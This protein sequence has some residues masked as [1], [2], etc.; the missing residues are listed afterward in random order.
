MA[1]ASDAEPKGPHW[2]HFLTLPLLKQQFAGTSPA[3]YAAVAGYKDE[4]LSKDVLTRDDV[5]NFCQDPETDPWIAFITIMAWGAQD[6]MPG[7]KSKVVAMFSQKEQ[8]LRNMECTLS[9]DNN[10][11]AFEIWSK[12]PVNKLGVAY[13]TKILFFLRYPKD[14]CYIMDAWT[15]RSYN[16]LVNDTII[17]KHHMN[18][19]S[20][21][22]VAASKYAE[23]CQFVDLVAERLSVREG[24][25]VNGSEAEMALFSVGGKQRA[26]W[27]SYVVSHLDKTHV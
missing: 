3:A 12:N 20:F 8:I 21:A 2:E 9:A 22:H 13:F 24:R 16:L 26:P 10:K 14:N 18:L 19:R 27:R 17:K 7:G 15:A 25:P 23:F 11:S 5:L 4:R 1:M 6:K